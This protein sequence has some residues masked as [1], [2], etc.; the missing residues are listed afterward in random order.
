[1]RW[2]LVTVH[3]GL[4]A[5]VYHESLALNTFD[6]FFTISMLLACTIRKSVA[7]I[8]L[9]MLITRIEFNGDLK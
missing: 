3:E 5:P 2:D 8:C 1:M 4:W 9:V 7:P 6:M